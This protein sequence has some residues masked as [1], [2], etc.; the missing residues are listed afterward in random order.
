MRGYRG[1]Y[2]KAD[3]RAI[4]RALFAGELRGVAATCA[5]E[6]GVDV[7]ELDATLHLGFPGR[8]PGSR[9]GDTAVTGSCRVVVRGTRLTRHGI[10]TRGGAPPRLPGRDRVALAAGG[11]THDSYR[12]A[13]RGTLL[14]R[15]VI[16]TGAIASLW[17]QAGR[18]GRRLGGG[19]C[20]ALAI[21]VCFDSP[22]DQFYVRHPEQVSR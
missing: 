17:Q 5:L 1:G 6:L 2:T 12:V 3:R 19:G 7:G 21:V 15:H 16:S 10:S 14:T 18:A 8:T 4:E 20:R 11:R 22:T 13:V 9:Q